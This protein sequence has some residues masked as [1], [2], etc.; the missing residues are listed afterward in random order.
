MQKSYCKS[1]LVPYTICQVWKSTFLIL[2]SNLYLLQMWYE[3]G[4]LWKLVIF[5]GLIPENL[6]L[7]ITTVAFSSIS[8]CYMA[9]GRLKIAKMLQ[10]TDF[11]QS[12]PQSTDRRRGRPC[13]LRKTKRV[14]EGFWHYADETGM[15]GTCFNYSQPSVSSFTSADLH[16]LG[17]TGFVSFCATEARLNWSSEW[18]A[19]VLSN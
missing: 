14:C 10:V 8:G 9:R 18:E 5:V 11:E 7:S 3:N 13:V 12:P 4:F 16:E 2:L 19:S 15:Y 17:G 1:W 6:Q